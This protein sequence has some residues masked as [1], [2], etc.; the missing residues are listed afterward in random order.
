MNLIKLLLVTL[1]FFSLTA[2]SQVENRTNELANLKIHKNSIKLPDF[3]FTEQ[4]GK[5]ISN[6]DLIGK[7]SVIN[8]WATWCSPCVQELP[9]FDRLAK[10]VSRENIQIYAVSQDRA[11]NKIVPHFFNKLNLKNLPVY[12]DNQGSLMASFKTPVLPT[13]IIVNQ[14]GMEVARLIGSINWDS[15]EVV[16]YLKKISIQK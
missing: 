6:S 15:K 4:S 3:Y 9:S 5:K 2:Y 7:V 14:E 16:D 12:L 8:L 11:G 10:V 13:T 1:I